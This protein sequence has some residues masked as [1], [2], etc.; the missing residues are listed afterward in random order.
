MLHYVCIPV[1]LIQ[2]N[3]YILR[4]EASGALAMVDCG[5]FNKEVREAVQ[6]Q[7]GDL[8]YILL[9]HGHF[10]HVQ[11]AAAA[12]AA[13]P[14]A[15]VAIGA[16]DAAYLRGEQET[17]AGRRMQESKTLEPDL[18]LADGDAIALGESKLRVHAAPGHTPGG[19]CLFCEE[20]RLLFTGDT[21][22]FEEVGRAD[23][24]GG[25]WPVLQESIRRL[26]A[27]PGDCTVLPGHGPAS[28]LSH[29]RAHNPY[30]QGSAAVLERP[31]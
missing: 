29:E 15:Q 25:D 3:T 4:D 28:T 12:K 30:V 22:F 1:G 31:V 2:S 19:I 5:V 10:D 24:V 18:L 26:Y 6:A 16:A 23:L 8:R 20:G 21:L 7:G 11:G 13:C 27:I 14:A 9:T 17:I